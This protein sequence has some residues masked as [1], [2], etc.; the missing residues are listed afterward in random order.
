MLPRLTSLSLL[1]GLVAVAAS[2]FTPA[3]A[4]EKP[5]IIRFGALASNGRPLTSGVPALFIEGIPKEFGADSI[6][7]EVTWLR[8]AGPGLNEAFVNKKVDF[9]MYGDFPAIAGKAGG[10]KTV[11]LAGYSTASN[12]ELVV[13]KDSGAQTIQ[14]LRGKRIAI[15][16]GRPWEIGFAYLLEEAG[17]KASDFK[18]V[19]LQEGDIPTAVA[20]NSVDAAYC[21]SGDLIE[22]RDIGR[23]IWSTDD[24]PIH[25]K[26]TSEL[27]GTEEFVNKYPEVTQRLVTLWVKSSHWAATNEEEYLRASGRVSGSYDLTVKNQ[28][29]RPVKETVVPIIDDFRIEHY[30]RSI[31]FLQKRKLIRTDIDVDSWLN[32]TFLDNAIKELKLEGF[33]NPRD[34]EGQFISASK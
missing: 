2:F 1:S 3:L 19:Y 22:K 17:L 12:S 20:A 11:W 33:W 34:K 29:G 13:P 26:Y 10:L 27:W 14:D 7:L 30:K 18:I 8:N 15:H 9:G 32:R 21:T 4:A 23:I 6:K 28:A 16:K 31:A 5:E 25:W 24:K